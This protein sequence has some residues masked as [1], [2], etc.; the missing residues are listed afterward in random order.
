MKKSLF[1]LFLVATVAYSQP[2][3]VKLNDPLLQNQVAF[4]I[5]GN[6][7]SPHYVR[8][9]ILKAKNISSSP[10][11]IQIENGLMLTP[12]D[13]DFQP[14]VITRE[15]LIALK[16]DQEITKELYGMCTKSFLVS[17]RDDIAYIPGALADTDLI[18]LTKMIGKDSLQ[19]IEA[20]HAVWA[21]V[22]DMPIE[23]IAGF[24]TTLVSDLVEV[25]ADVTGQMIPEPPAEDDYRRNYYSRNFS[26]RMSGE[27]N[28]TYYDTRSVSIAMFNKDGVVVRE[29]Y[30]NPQMLPGHHVLEFEFDATHFN[31]EYYFIRVIDDGEI[32]INMKIETLGNPGGRG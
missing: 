6:P 16:P 7:D 24:D 10:V 17:P 4:Q 13:V 18:R 12:E 3:V 15:E 25:V 1:L 30:N 19:N 14:I 23:D 26:R 20:Q 28:C 11:T 5:T 21:I 31:D 9:L 32:S 2:K 8:P 27:F 22:D 29:L